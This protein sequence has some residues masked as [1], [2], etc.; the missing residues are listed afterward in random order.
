MAITGH[1]K[2]K[3][4]SREENLMIGLVDML[5]RYYVTYYSLVI[6]IY[7]YSVIQKLTVFLMPDD[8]LDVL[9]LIDFLLFDI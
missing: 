3:V 9:I 1:N 2:L 5:Y 4:F 6:L 8:W 7:L